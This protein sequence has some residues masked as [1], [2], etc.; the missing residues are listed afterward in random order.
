[1]NKYNYFIN[2][3]FEK[4]ID[5]IYIIYINEFE[6]NQIKYKVN[7]YLPNKKIIFF[8]GIN[9]YNESEFNDFHNKM[10]NDKLLL[11]NSMIE[12]YCNINNLPVMNIN[13][14]KGRYGCNIPYIKIIINNFYINIKPIKIY[15]KRLFINN[16]YVKLVV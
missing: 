11:D 2:K 6:L 3:N 4:L 8:K 10:L 15:I 7:K 14:N 13:I 9:G 16:I 5:K 12:K 1:M